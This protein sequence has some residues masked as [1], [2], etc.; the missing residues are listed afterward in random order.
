MWTVNADDLLE[1]GAHPLA[2]VQRRVKDLAGTELGLIRSSFR[3]APLID[4]LENQGFRTAVVCSGD[5][6]ATFIGLKSE[7]R[8][9]L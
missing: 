1:A 9:H 4:L 3:P 8:V 6:F 7:D 5:S 2:E